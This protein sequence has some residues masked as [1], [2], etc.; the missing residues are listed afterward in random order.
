MTTDTGI[1]HDSVLVTGAGGFIGSHV[2]DAL[3]AA[4]VRVTGFDNFCDFYAP[5]RK[6]ENLRPAASHPA[7]TII[8]GDVRDGDALREAFAA[9]RPTA[10]IH[11]AAMAGVRPSIDR[12]ALYAAVNV[13]GT[14]RVLQACAEV[15]CATMLFASSSS[16]Y[17]ESERVPFVE[18]DPVNRPVSPYAATKVAGEM[19]CHTWHH[20]HGMS[21]TCLRFF[22]VYGPR[23]RPDLAI[24][25]FMTCARDGRPARMYGNGSSSRDYTFVSDIVDGVLAALRHA[26]GFHL[27]NLGSDRP[28]SLKAMLDAIRDATG[29]DLEIK[30]APDQPG[31]VARTWAD[32]ARSEA[33]LGYR[34]RT[35]LE[36]G[37]RRQWAWMQ[38]TELSVHRAL[39]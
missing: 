18:T 31:D 35:T 38:Q 34:P 13:E 16:V 23:Q 27:F 9:T 22:T 28:V 19:L 8:T 21:I 4:G 37:L 1:P 5:A 29:R 6:R 2:V 26:S 20:L 30:S 12:P 10:V 14:A 39:R 15:G 11:L 32:L 36:E 24:S 3:L 25:R 33:A 17:G 7:C